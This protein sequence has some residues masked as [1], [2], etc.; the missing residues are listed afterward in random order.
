MTSLKKA[1][2]LQLILMISVL[3]VS[4]WNHVGRNFVLGFIIGF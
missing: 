3:I 4:L 2:L 1:S